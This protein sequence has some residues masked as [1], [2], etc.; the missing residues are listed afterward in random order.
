MLTI[1]NLLFFGG[2][3]VTNAST[4]DNTYDI[5]I[6]TNAL[7]KINNP[8]ILKLANNLNNVNPNSPTYDLIIRKAD[9]NY[10]DIKKIAKAI[11]AIHINKG[12]SLHTISMNF[13]EN[14][15]D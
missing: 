9:L 3:F 4:K 14:L 10:E 7:T 12:P 11:K 2:T 1:I 8:K 6:L 13:N 5:E 15:R